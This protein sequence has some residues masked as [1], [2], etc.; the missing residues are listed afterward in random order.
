MSLDVLATVIRGLVSR[1]AD[2]PPA[3]HRIS[4]VSECEVKHCTL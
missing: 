4:L 1:G 2:E 3:R